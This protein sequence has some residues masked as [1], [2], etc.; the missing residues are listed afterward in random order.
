M[1]GCFKSLIYFNLPALLIASIE[2]MLQ[3]AAT[4]RDLRKAKVEL[5]VGQTLDRSQILQRAKAAGLRSVPLVLAPGECSVRGDVVDIYPMAADGALRLEF[6]DDTL[7]SIRSFD[8]ATQRTTEVHESYALGLAEEG[9]AELGTV[10]KHL[11]P[12]KT[13]VVTFEQ[14]RIDERSAR[15]TS[16]DSTFGPRKQRLQ[17]TLHPCPQ[18]ELSSLPSHEYDYKVLSAGSAAGSGESDPAGRLRSVRG[19]QGQV[20]LFCRSADEAERLDELLV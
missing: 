14:L 19:I 17:D 12:S 8:P 4:P 2:A 5:R 1:D 18:V 9:D 10:V 16:F 13:L 11:T 7:E 3:P 6:F 15:L 20:L